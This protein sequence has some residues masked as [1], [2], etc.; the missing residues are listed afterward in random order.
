M[1]APSLEC[2]DCMAAAAGATYSFKIGCLGCT[3]R[4][5]ARG[6]H[7]FRVRKAGK[8]D[9]EYIDN[10]TRAGVTHQQVKDA[11]AGDAMM[12]SKGERKC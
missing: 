1:N 7:Y 6:P 3:A 10:I 11:S 12:N 9:H 4:Q 5:I 2:F 8:L